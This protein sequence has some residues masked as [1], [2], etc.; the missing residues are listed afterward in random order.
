MVLSLAGCSTEDTIAPVNDDVL[1][2]E[3]VEVGDV[4]TV[5]DA[6]E[7]V[8]DAVSDEPIE[9]EEEDFKVVEDE[10]D[11]DIPLF[12]EYSGTISNIE[13][14]NDDISKITI[15]T[16]EEENIEVYMV[17]DDTYFLDGY[18]P[19]VG[20]EITAYKDASKPVIMIYPPQYEAVA[21]VK[22]SEDFV[23]IKVDKFSPELL[24]SDDQLKLNISD[25][26]VIEYRDGVE[27]VETL[28]GKTLL[29]VY[30]VTTRSIPAQTSPI[31]VVVLD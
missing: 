16:L 5:E 15:G 7:V 11:I 20:D 30:D 1:V 26:T 10:L 4:E 22:N 21:I 19:E 25:E 12:M 27:E 24:S 3:D 23:N 17:T 28:E 8:E 14:V 2:V 13:I 6:V 31:K 18:V 29:V 9:L